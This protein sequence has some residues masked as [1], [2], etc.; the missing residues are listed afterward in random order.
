MTL[1]DPENFDPKKEHGGAKKL[2]TPQKTRVERYSNAFQNALAKLL[3]IVC[4][5]AQVAYVVVAGVL[6]VMSR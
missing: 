4:N 1:P 5:T 6:Q 3:I 2:P